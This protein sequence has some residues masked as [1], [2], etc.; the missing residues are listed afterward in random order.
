VTDSG[1]AATPDLT[2]AA[3]RNFA[4]WHEISVAALGYRSERVAGGWLS[5]DPIPGIY[6]GLVGTDPR[7]EPSIL[8]SELVRR[9]RDGLPASAC[10]P[11][12]A[13][14]LGPLGFA[15]GA[16]QPWWARDP[17]P[18]PVGSHP[19]GVSVE[20]VR[21]EIELARY[22]AI[23][24]EGFGIPAGP[25]FRWHGP[26]LLVDRR[27]TI[28]L[29]RLDGRPAAAAMAFVEA[30][31]VGVYGVTTVPSARGRGLATALTGHAVAVAPRLPTVLQPSR[32]AERLYERLDFRSFAEFATWARSG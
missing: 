10:D 30:G 21:S 29:G 31:V 2:L 19:R 25:P 12:G 13:L 20:V 1:P 17:G 5:V 4:A 24:A 9:S 11:F 7:T 3:A 16:L 27:L 32:E 6:F 8:T 26:P 15:R 23:S 18:A 22:E 28:F 14:D